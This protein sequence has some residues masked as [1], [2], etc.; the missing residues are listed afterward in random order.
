[1]TDN[2]TFVLG[3]HSQEKYKFTTKG[4]YQA[5]KTF[6]KLLFSEEI[7]SISDIWKNFEK[8]NTESRFHTLETRLKYSTSDNR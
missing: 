4:N 1:M 8:N 5:K 7:I 2:F 3:S 6:P